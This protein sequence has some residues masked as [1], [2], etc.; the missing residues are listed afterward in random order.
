MTVS[1]KHKINSIFCDALEV[2]AEHRSEFVCAATDDLVVRDEVLKMLERERAIGGF[3]ETLPVMELERDAPPRRSFEDGDVVAG[4]YRIV[5]LIQAGGMGE[6]YQAFDTTL[7]QQIA[8]KTV[9]PQI[10]V[11][12]A[13]MER[14]HREVAL[15]RNI[16]HQNIC[17]VFDLGEHKHADGH[18]T[19][20]LTMEYLRGETLR[21]RLK[22]TGRMTLP[23]AM[24]LIR[25]MADALDA[26]HQTGVIHRDF[27]PGNVMLVPRIDGPERVVVT[28]FG[29]AISMQE[30][31][32]SSPLTQS[33]QVLGTPDYMAPEQW[34]GA[35]AGPATDIY[36]F[37][38]VIQEMLG[39]EA[40]PAGRS[41]TE[42]WRRVVD[43]CLTADP[44]ARPQSVPDVVQ[45]LE[46][47]R[48]PG[49]RTARARHWP[50]AIAALCIAVALLFAFF[51]YP[52]TREDSPPAAVEHR[53]ALLPVRVDHPVLSMFA[54]GLTD[55]IT[56]RLAQYEPH[57]GRLFIV[58]ASE[59]RRERVQS[60]ST[61]KA[62]FGVRYAIEASLQ[63]Q[64]DRVRLAINVIDT[65]TLH[66]KESTFI[67]GSVK[68]ALELQDAAVVKLANMLDMRVQPKHAG[69]LNAASPL[70]PGAYEFYLQAKGYLK[71]NDRLQDVESAISV[72]HNALELDP[73]YAP[74]H[75]ALGEAYWYKYQRTSD[76][77]WAD[78]A[79][80]VCRKALELNPQ[81]AEAHM[82]LGMVL[83]GKGQLKEGV[84]EFQQ[85]L[86]ISPRNVDIY[87]G[88]GEAYRAAKDYGNAE[89][90]FRKAVELQRQDWRGYKQLGLMYRDQSEY[91]KAIEQFEQ[92][93][94]LTPDNAAAYNALGALYGMSKNLTKAEQMLR[95][96]LSI[97]P[98][99]TS[100]L[101]N[102]TKLLFDQG[103]YP[104]AAVQWEAAAKLDPSSY[105]LLGN[106]AA[107]YA[108]LGR[109][110]DAKKTYEA[111]IQL[112]THQLTV[113]PTS[114]ELRSFRAHFLAPLGRKREAL[115]D[116]AKTGS[117]HGNDVEVLIRD[118]YSYV[119]VEEIP[120]ARELMRKALSL[121]YRRESAAKNDVL[122]K[123]LD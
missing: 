36:A 103:R 21:E 68:R 78:Q 91:G 6:V 108:K 37:G 81:L 15:A 5:R 55:A 25:Q 94:R 97:E 53:V 106:L 69:E 51:R 119:E 63:A 41:R 52:I 122:R 99:R 42:S 17:H 85:A 48:F 87:L 70:N 65:A 112:V 72:L 44:K 67:D 104:E 33:G 92:I 54:E 105:V 19:A 80:R 84:H 114:G 46:G 102:L 77:R 16:T 39:S 31:T 123:A 86:D 115:T 1:H 121:G 7:D 35:P 79:L 61:A 24:P 90:S 18:V 28:D 83:S 89:A 22:Q 26:A 57:S 4:R 12:P 75:T 96:A 109:T 64:D 9:L 56:T 60:A 93:V 11:R 47:R 107:V 88:L 101:D 14:F 32:Q 3:M 66:H 113:N 8:L 50:S 118:A 13:V 40:R 49:S 111:A 117:L 120:R 74:A 100:A 82:A 95:K 116:L 73:E 110:E 76:T 20:F 34:T 59:L 62:K 58:P 45:A 38:R 30:R 98:T 2:P 71:R 23:A 10:Q 29:L 43:W 27:K